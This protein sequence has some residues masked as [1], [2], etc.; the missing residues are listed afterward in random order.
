MTMMNRKCLGRTVG[1]AILAFFLVLLLGTP[2]HAEEREITASGSCG[3][4]ASWT[5]DSDGV[6]TDVWYGGT[7]SDREKM[8]IKERNDP[9][10]AAVWH[11]A[12]PPVLGIALTI[13]P[14]TVVQGEQIRWQAY[15]ADENGTPAEGVQVDFRL[16]NEAGELIQ[17]SGNDVYSNTTDGYGK[18]ALKCNFPSA[19]PT[20]RYRILLTIHDTEVTAE[21][22]FTVAAAETVTYRLNVSSLTLAVNQSVRLTLV[23]SDGSAGT[24]TWSSSDPSVAS[25]DQNGLVTAKKYGKAVIT[26]VMEDGFSAGC[27]VRTL[28]WDVTGSPD[29]N[30]PN[31]QYFYNAV[32][33]AAEKGIARGYSNGVHAGAFGV[34][35]DCERQDFILFLYRLAG[36]PAPDAAVLADLDRTF[37]DVSKLSDSFRKAI[38]WGY[39][40]GII[41]GYTSGANQGKFGNG[42]PIT[43]R[44][45]MIMLWRYAG[46]PAPSSTGLKS[47]RSF[48][49]VKGKYKETSDSFKAIAWA[50]GAGIA[51]GYTR[52][53]S[54]PPGSGRTVPCYGCDLS[55]FR[56][57]MITFLY[58]YAGQ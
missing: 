22:W 49:D 47:A 9:L 12:D 50:A 25:V 46:K 27:D 37:S 26:A 30:D 10:T 23:G 48:T 19:Y 34:G 8:S 31:Y 43:R 15:V 52:E 35:L 6:L 4:Q 17:L 24:G 13:E 51:N 45:A 55:C 39:H 56:E 32:Y 44:E 18:C 2:V 57:Q 40:K 29:K 11:Y 14:E 3:E 53:S 58:R 38:A 54:L 1:T 42:L 28:F 20:G 41:K 33:W 7:E 36:Q 5:L 16:F 21:G